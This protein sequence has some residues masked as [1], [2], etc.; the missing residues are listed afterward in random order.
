M[1]EIFRQIATM[2]CLP[3]NRGYKSLNR[4]QQEHRFIVYV[5]PSVL[6][7]CASKL[8][9]HIIAAETGETI[10]LLPWTEINWE[11]S[12]HSPNL[13][14]QLCRTLC[15]LISSYISYCWLSVFDAVI[16]GFTI[17]GHVRYMIMASDGIDV[18]IVA[19]IHISMSWS[20][21]WSVP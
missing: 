18:L 21:R 5:S 2:S 7:Y 10:P 3:I 19:Q 1:L 15:S 4:S 9:L 12:V 11:G 20:L 6:Q 17:K 8:V 13:H 14:I 16:G